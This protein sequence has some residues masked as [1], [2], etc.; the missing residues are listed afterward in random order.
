MRKLQALALVTVSACTHPSA[1]VGGGEK[2]VGPAVAPPATDNAPAPAWPAA[3]PRAIAA[4]PPASGPPVSLT[5]SDGSGL[6]IVAY[7]ARAVVE[8][9]LAFT[10]LHLVFRNPRPRAIEG[11]FEITLPP[12]AVVSRFAM[13]QSWGW[14]EGEV[15]E[16]Q[17]ARVAYEDFLHRRQDPALLEKQAGNRFHA[18]VF[19]IAAS[20]DKEL[21]VSYTQELPRADEPY[22]LPLRGL[23]RLASLDIRAFVGKRTARAA[24]SSLGG[25]AYSHEVV[26]V[27]R[28]GFVPDVD[29]EVVPPA[30]AGGARVGLRHENLAVARLVPVVDS[31]P[32]PIDGGLQILVD[33]S[34]SRALDLPGDVERLGSL[35]GALARVPG[36]AELPLRIACFDQEVVEVYAGRAGDLGRKPL[37]R[38]LDR[39]ALGASDLAQALRAAGRARG[40]SRVLLLTDGIATAGDTEGKDLRAAAVAL[41]QSGVRRLDVLVSGGL[42]DEPA[43]KALATAGLAHDGLVLDGALPVETVVRKLGSATF[44]HVKVEVPGAR[45]VWPTSLDGLQPGD[46]VLVYADLPADRP[47]EIQL[48]GAHAARQP[49]ALTEVERPLLERA[50][51][52]A[53]IQKLA[54]QRETLAASDEDLRSALKKEIVELSTKYRVLSDYTGL[55][56]LETEADY[57]RFH[58]DRRALSDILVVGAT[59]IE[60]MNRGPSSTPPAP[61]QPTVALESPG[62]KRAPFERMKRKAMSLRGSEEGLMGAAGAR[63]LATGD[64]MGGAAFDGESQAPRGVPVEVAERPA[65]P[66]AAVARPAEQAPLVA[67]AS[68]APAPVAAAPVASPPPP[69]AVVPAPAPAA[70]PEPPPRHMAHN[71]DMDSLLDSPSEPARRHRSPPRDE[72]AEEAPLVR[73]AP[74]AHH[75]VAPRIEAAPAGADALM[76][77][78][79]LSSGALQ[80]VLRRADEK[81]AERAPYDGRF[82]EVMALVGKHKAKDALRAALAWHD[83]EPGDVLALIAVGEAEELRGARGE[84]ARAYG[85]IIDLF[86]SRADLRRFAGERLERLGAAGLPLAIDTFRKARADRPDHPASHR[87][88]AFALLRDGHPDEAFDVILDGIRQPYP[89]GRFLGVDRILRE[90]AG[91]IAAAWLRRHP[92]KR[93]AVL[94]RLGAVSAALPT[95]RSLRFVLNWE[96]DA[97]DVDF[98]IHDARGGHAFYS[99]KALPSGGELYADVTTGYGP[100]CF[101]IPGDPA[102]YPYRLQAHYYSRGPMGYGMGKLEIIEDDGQGQLRFEERPFVVMVDGAFVELGEVKGPL[103]RLASK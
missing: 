44:S 82:A 69:V 62:T 8:D 17:A 94:T 30:A 50:W 35:V 75:A 27:Q 64:P 25:T 81:P 96:T 46:E 2:D 74:R 12:T 3:P 95:G 31:A 11:Q 9:P 32:D 21:I 55:V 39:R 88:L 85:S 51:V 16:L 47:L 40:Y 42:R 99:S 20:G 103:P 72:V 66:R 89:G 93:D 22:R 56:V 77:R 61:P 58:I 7:Q 102:A 97:N 54:H 87:L 49:I 41:G 100:E 101:T 14:Q 1:L 80:M 60:L 84:A 15:V 4:A 79:A 59:G 19:P 36:G 71:D 6:E 78:P 67:P 38:I 68:P 90:D 33:T 63:S 13:K 52:N 23:P 86:P 43:L 18:R 92:E 76:S 28:R 5:A 34:A 65:P 37:D 45:W 48:D 26:E 10:E 29:F 24:A 57:A 73:E 98:H 53:R 91:L 83:A 70:R